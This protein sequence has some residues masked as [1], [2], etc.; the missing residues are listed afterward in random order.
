MPGTSLAVYLHYGFWLFWTIIVQN[1]KDW[2][3]E[4]SWD[5]P[6]THFD[7]LLAEHSEALLRKGGYRDIPSTPPP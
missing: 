1:S 3:E 6:G 5:V 7:T 4:E 2:I